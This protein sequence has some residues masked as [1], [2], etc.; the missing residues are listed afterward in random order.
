MSTRKRSHRSKIR[1]ITLSL[2]IGII[3]GA[4]SWSLFPNFTNNNLILPSQQEQI[5]LFTHPIREENNNSISQPI[6]I[7]TC[8]TPPAGC[9]KVIT[10]TIDLA[11]KS[12]YIQAYGFTDTEIASSLISAYNRGVKVAILLDKSNL[13]SKNPQISKVKA[14]GIDVSID[15]VPGIAHNK[16]IIIDQHTVITGSFNFSKNANL[17][18]VENVIIVNDSL[19]AKQYFQNWLSRKQVN[20]KTTI[21]DY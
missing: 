8:F 21:R 17:K 5:P 7:S 11:T 6:K 9:S 1:N 10:K 12:I 18:N 4:T 2:I 13:Y 19:I 20:T 15:N 3:L 14:A 16:V